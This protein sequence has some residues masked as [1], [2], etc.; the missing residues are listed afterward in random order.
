[1]STVIERMYESCVVWDGMY[2]FCG[3]VGPRI[4]LNSKVAFV[5]FYNRNP[6]IP[7]LFFVNNWEN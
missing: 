4:L 3:N 7:Y 1:M 2:W 6:G 5:I